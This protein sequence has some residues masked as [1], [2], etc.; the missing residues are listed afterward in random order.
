MTQDYDD[1]TPEFD[2]QPETHKLAP[3]DTDMTFSFT[4]IAAL[5]AVVVLVVVLFSQR[6]AIVDN[7]HGEKDMV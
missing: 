7:L 5:L 4:K 3:L 6:N 1:D 2:E